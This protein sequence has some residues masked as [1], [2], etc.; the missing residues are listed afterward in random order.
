MKTKT[1]SIIFCAAALTACQNVDDT[2][3]LS[4]DIT[5]SSLQ[6]VEWNNK[7]ISYAIL[8]HSNSCLN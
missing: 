6:T 1:L 5:V 4:D 3:E 8:A 2:F 7:C